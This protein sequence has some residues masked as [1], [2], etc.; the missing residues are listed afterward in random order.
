MNKLDIL[1][2]ERVFLVELRRLPHFDSI[3]K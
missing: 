2:L 3:G 1:F